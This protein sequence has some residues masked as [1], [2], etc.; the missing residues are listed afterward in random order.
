MIPAN[1]DF[2]VF[3]GDSFNIPSIILKN[4]DLTVIDISDYI[5]TMY[6]YGIEDGSDVVE[7]SSEDTDNS[8]V[9]IDGANGKITINISEAETVGYL[10]NSKYELKIITDDVT[11]LTHTILSGNIN[12][13]LTINTV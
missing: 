6:I 7:Y 4:D 10:Y 1:K 13:I 3:Q 2:K 9:T 8:Y 5:V 11:P 12:V